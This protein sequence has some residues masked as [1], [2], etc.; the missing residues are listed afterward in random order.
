MEM[1]GKWGPVITAANS[2]NHHDQSIAQETAHSGA[3][4]HVDWNV[5]MPRHAGSAF[6]IVCCVVHIIL[7]LY[8]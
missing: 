1:L 7:N 8:P 5:G 3:P 6:V 4:S 2:A